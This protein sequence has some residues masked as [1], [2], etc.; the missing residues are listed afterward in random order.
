MHHC[1]N[2]QDYRIVIG[3]QERMTHAA[4]D[5]AQSGSFKPR[6]RLSHLLTTSI[7]MKLIK[8]SFGSPVQTRRWSDNICCAETIEVGS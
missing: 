3:I 4:V 2:E 8:D 6:S 1:R 5:R 7:S